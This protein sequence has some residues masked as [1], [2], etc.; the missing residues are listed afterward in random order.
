MNYLELV[1]QF[2][3]VN[4][5]YPFQPIDSFLY[6]YLVETCNKLRWKNPFGHS[7]RHLAANLR[8]SVNTVRVSKNR[9]IEAGLIEVSTP[10]KRSKGFEGQSSYFLKTVSISDTV[11]PTVSNINTVPDTVPDTNNK[12]N[13]SVNKINDLPDVKLYNNFCEFDRMV[14]KMYPNVAQL[15]HQMTSTE[16]I[17][18]IKEYNISQE[19][20]TNILEQMENFKPLKSK[21]TS[22]N[23]TIRSWH[24]N[25]I[26]RIK[27][28]AVQN[29]SFTHEYKSKISLTSEG[30]TIGNK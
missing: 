28:S 30:P 20:L 3:R 7:D 29:K 8:V 5:E 16:Y 24:K 19:A 9:L 4:L 17:A 6:Y 14:Q 13:N 1:R 23:L 12:Q 27:I 10:M 2:W 11:H 18:L 15:E 25:H 21:Y 22:V 26:E